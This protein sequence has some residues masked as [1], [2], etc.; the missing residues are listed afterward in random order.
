[1]A[2]KKPKYEVFCRTRFVGFHRWEYANGDVAFLK[3]THRH[4]FRVEVCVR[5]DHTDRNI[6]F[7]HLKSQLDREIALQFTSDQI[8]PILYS[9]ELIAEIIGRYLISQEYHPIYVEVSEDG[10][11]GGRVRYE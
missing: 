9:C 1:M 3:N 10:E 11:N 2:V 6:E 4:E 8:N 7:T 5:V